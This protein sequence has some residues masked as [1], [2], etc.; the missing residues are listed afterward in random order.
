MAHD[1]DKSGDRA[2]AAW[3][4]RARRVRPPGA[5][6]DW[7]EA[8]QAGVNLHRWWSD[9][10]AGTEAPPLFTWNELS[11]QRWGP[12]ER[13]PRPGI[14]IPADDWRWTVAG[15]PQERWA[16]WRRRAGEMLTHGADAAQIREAERQ[17][18]ELRPENIVDPF[19]AYMQQHQA[20]AAVTTPGS[21]SKHRDAFG[22]RPVL[23][24]LG[25]SSAAVIAV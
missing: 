9:R 13:E 15:W 11:R 5:F 24:S 8:A 2:A 21:S 7:T 19:A 22:S 14:E 17:L 20:S 25:S 18:A 4:A 16:A 12:A 3:P 6:K 10:L 23:Q 1:A